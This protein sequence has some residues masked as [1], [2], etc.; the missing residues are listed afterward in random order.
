MKQEINMQ[1]QSWKNYK[2]K[3]IKNKIYTKTKGKAF[4]H[5]FLGVCALC[6]LNLHRTT[7][8]NNNNNNNNN[9]NLQIAIIF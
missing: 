1:H 5:K 8:K 4:T 3:K 9:N 7:L 6:F 2:K